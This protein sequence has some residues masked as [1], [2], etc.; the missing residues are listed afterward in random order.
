ML[1]KEA[2]AAFSKESFPSIS[3]VQHSE[4]TS[5]EQGTE[6]VVWSQGHAFDPVFCLPSP[7][8]QLHPKESVQSSAPLH[9]EHTE[10]GTWREAQ[11][12]QP[13]TFSQPICCKN[14][15]AEEKRGLSRGILVGFFFFLF[16]SYS[17]CWVRL[18]FL[19]PFSPKSWSKVLEVENAMGILLSLV[20]HCS[21]SPGWPASHF[22]SARSTE[23]A[24]LTF[25]YP[26]ISRDQSQWEEFDWDVGVG[27]SA[28]S[29]IPD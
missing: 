17:L 25:L 16:R 10:P 5:I 21:V 8:L 2:S 14:K 1:K 29:Q 18:K 3:T 6:S 22:T 12:E 19:L 9:P 20:W 7:L 24:H 28:H 26:F 4:F 27:S 15:G 23:G 13:R 11:A